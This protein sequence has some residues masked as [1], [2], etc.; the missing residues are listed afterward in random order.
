[1][2]RGIGAADDVVIA[3]GVRYSIADAGQR[4]VMLEM[5]NHN[6]ARMYTTCK[7]RTVPVLV[8]SALVT[9]VIGYFIG[10]K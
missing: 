8:F 4:I 9:G 5:S 2:F 1:M 6:Q 7:D 10:K 3:N